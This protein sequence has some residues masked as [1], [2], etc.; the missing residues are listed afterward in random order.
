[1]ITVTGEYA[2]RAVL[3]LSRR[4]PAPQ[5]AAEVARAT[6]MPL[7]YLSKIMQSLVKAQVVQSQRGLRGGFHLA[8]GP[9]EISVLQVINA[10]GPPIPRMRRCPLAANDHAGDCPI[11]RLAD[12]GVRLIEDAFHSIK[13]DALLRLPCG[14]GSGGSA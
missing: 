7:G 4:H 14:A 5:T 1:M 2:L 8:R 13:M 11:R 6:G 3:Q 9:E 10:A 12:D